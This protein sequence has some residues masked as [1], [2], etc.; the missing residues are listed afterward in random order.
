MNKFASFIMITSALLL[1]AC[2][3]TP[4]VDTRPTGHDSVHVYMDQTLEPVM[5]QQL[6]IYD[7]LQ[8]T[9]NIKP[10]FVPEAE[11]MRKLANR[12]ADIIIIARNVETAETD[13][14]VQKD[15]LY[16]KRFDLAKDAVAIIT[17]VESP[18]SSFKTDELKDMLVGKPGGNGSQL[19][20]DNKQSGIIKNIQQ[21][22]G[23][24]VALSTGMYALNSSMEVIDYVQKNKNAIGFISYSVISDTDDLAVK[25]LLGKVKVL[26]LKQKNDKGEEMEVSANQSDVSSGDYPLIRPVIAVTPY[27][28][29]DSKEWDFINFLMR[30]KGARIFLKAGLVPGTIP[31]RE[32]RINTKPVTV[33]E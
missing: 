11:L 19:V 1:G 12:E 6:E 4:M 30:E 17:S 9:V 22:L 10:F 27:K 7:Y 13:A 33:T 25:E 5:A 3:N 23:K 28:L 31:A 29:G 8:D 18:V 15:S 26:S 20:F 14:L 16:T 32:V 2:N 21:W 24:G